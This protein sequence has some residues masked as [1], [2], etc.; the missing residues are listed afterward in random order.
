MT[1]LAVALGAN[2]GGLSARTVQADQGSG[3]QG[4]PDTYGPPVWM[5]IPIIGVDSAVSDVKV[6]DGFYDVPWFD[7]GHHAD[8]PSPGD[9]GNSIFDGH[10]L[11]INAGRVFYRLHELQPGDAVYMYSPMYRTDWVV[12][13]TFA[14]VSDDSS[15][16]AQTGVPQVTL[17]T[18]SGDYNPLEQSFSQRMV[19]VGT[20]VGSSPV[21]TR[22]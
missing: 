18:C 7:V 12:T 13:D 3:A 22:P 20:L 9:A 10:V 1:A 21:T 4:V 6:V 11:T 17:Y 2:A 8:S 5:R 15:F 19:V 14:A 16:L